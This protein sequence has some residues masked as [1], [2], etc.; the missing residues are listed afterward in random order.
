MENNLIVYLYFFFLFSVDCLLLGGEAPA[1][2]LIVSVI[3]DINT[4][5]A[6]GMHQNKSN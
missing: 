3:N 2:L 4:F 1:V 6:F 5:L